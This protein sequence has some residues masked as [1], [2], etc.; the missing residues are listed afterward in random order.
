MRTNG[1]KHN[2]RFNNSDY[3]YTNNYRIGYNSDEEDYNEL[4]PQERLQC[5]CHVTF[6]VRVVFH[7]F[8]QARHCI[9]FQIGKMKDDYINQSK[10]WCW[11]SLSNLNLIMMITYQLKKKKK[12]SILKT[13]Q[14]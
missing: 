4:L 9:F 12:I 7:Y 3:K 2:V 1:N 10:M 13:R 14:R 6:R 8:T 5:T 11:T